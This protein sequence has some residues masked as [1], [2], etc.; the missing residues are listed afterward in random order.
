M[1]HFPLDI[2]TIP[3]VGHICTTVSQIVP[4][5]APVRDGNDGAGSIAAVEQAVEAW[6]QE[7]V[8]G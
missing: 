3:L 6:R 2:Y 5:Y 1:A 8:W 4:V 7:E